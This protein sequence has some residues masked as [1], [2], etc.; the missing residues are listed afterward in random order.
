MKMEFGK[1]VTRLLTAFVFFK[2]FVLAFNIWYYFLN[3]EQY[4]K[5]PFTFDLFS[6]LWAGFSSLVADAILITIAV[7]LLLPKWREY[8][9]EQL[10]KALNKETPS[11]FV[12][13]K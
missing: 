9:E 12:S 13:G 11:V 3:F 2:F 8:H 6:V 4:I 1:N 7:L 10:M 5:L